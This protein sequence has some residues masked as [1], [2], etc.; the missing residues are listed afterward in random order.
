[1]HNLHRDPD[2]HHEGKTKKQVTQM[3]VRDKQKATDIVRC[4][5]QL[6]FLCGHF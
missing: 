1:M 5:N 4:L 3:I 2:T 6:R